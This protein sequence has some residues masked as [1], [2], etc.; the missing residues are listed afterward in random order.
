[1][2]IPRFFATAVSAPAAVVS[3]GVR[4]G[5]AARRKVRRAGCKAP[6]SRVILF[7]RARLWVSG[8]S[9]KLPGSRGKPPGRSARLPGRSAST[10]GR[11]RSRVGECPMVGRREAM[12]KE[13]GAA[14]W[15]SP[16]RSM[17]WGSGASRRSRR[18]SQRRS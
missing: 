1:M 7:P 10:C 2:D 17:R 5:P 8:S 6:I 3:G 15:G 12:C 13:G 18:R 14:G 16:R 11:D 4:R 9:G